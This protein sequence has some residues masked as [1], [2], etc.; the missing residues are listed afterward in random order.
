M[1]HDHQLAGELIWLSEQLGHDLHWV[2]ERYTALSGWHMFPA[3]VHP[4]PVQDE[5]I[6]RLK[7]AELL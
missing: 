4:K 3:T 2:R 5:T 7:S 6:D 1:R